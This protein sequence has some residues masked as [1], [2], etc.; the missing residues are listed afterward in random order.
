VV[1]PG[2][3]LWSVASKAMPGLDPRE[4]VDHLR[5]LNGLDTAVVVPGQALKVPADA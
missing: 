1:Q 3:T 4:A 2:D 5:D